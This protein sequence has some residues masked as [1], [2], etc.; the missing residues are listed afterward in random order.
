[1]AEA[2]PRPEPEVA[3]G[4][5]VPRGAHTAEDVQARLRRA[6]AGG[7][8]RAREKLAAQGKL[9]VRERIGR[10]LDP[11]A[12]FVED[13]LLANCEAADLPADGV[14]TGIG[15]LHGR[16][17]AV[18]ANDPSV[19]AGSW[20][21]RTVE[22]IVRL[23]ET[24]ER[25]QVPLV[26]LVDSAGAR[27]TDQVA[28]FPGR[29]GAGRIFH[30][31]VRLSGQVP[32][33]CV[34]FGPSAAGGAYIPAFCDAVIMVEGNASMYLG[35]PRMAEVVVGERVTL[36]EMGGAR[37]HCSVSGC[38]DVLVEDEEAALS[39]AR[40]YL[41]YMPS[42]WR[43]APAPAAPRPP[44][45][46]ARPVDE[47]IPLEAARGYDAMEVIRALVDEGS[48]LEVKRLFARE[49]VTGFA[50]IDGRAVGVVASQPRFKGGVLFVD[51]ADK[52]AR[53]VTLCDAF[54]IPLLWLADVPGFMIGS[55]VE[56]QGIIR[57]G[58]KMIAA[59]AAASVPKLCV[60]LRKSYGAGLYAMC[61]PA[62]EPDC[63]IALPSAQ[64]AVMG[65]EAA[66]NA[67][68]Y[69]RI[70]ELPEEERAAYVRRLQDEY[71]DDIDIFKLAG[72]LVVD[73]VVPAPLLRDELVARLAAYASRRRTE[74]AR[75]H[76]VFPV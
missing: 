76:G 50:R 10:L 9:P 52:G 49:L 42:S 55:A 6:R 1:V 14:V 68:Y 62:F 63:T 31:E 34:L 64:I 17:C 18:M 71:R 8:E 48:F 56:R 65:P 24:A 58:A 7:P 38:G 22:K 28:M 19:K 33:L 61:G 66:V 25:L 54:N 23:Q 70:Q 39:A 69:N 51:S 35:S 75:H 46:T 2:P 16:H 20:G 40:D 4:A 74:V 37:M 36:E 15:V 32:Q 43:E 57:H 26:Y 59:L 21:A 12:A 60:V 3:G 53:F 5:P 73:A 13:G 30:M 29:R 45:A 67:V 47:V 27:I 44:P 41:S 11:G 72:E